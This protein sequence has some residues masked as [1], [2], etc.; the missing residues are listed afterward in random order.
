MPLI[1]YEPHNFSSDSQSIIDQANDI[2]TEYEQQ[3][4]KLTVRQ[5][6]YQFVSR[7]LIANA[8]NGIWADDRWKQIKYKEEIKLVADN[9]NKAVEAIKEG[10]NE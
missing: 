9:W 3:G 7:G 8:D 5:L 2:I 6:Y 4:Y 1:E 10:E